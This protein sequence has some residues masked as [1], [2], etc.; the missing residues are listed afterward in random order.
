[1]KGEPYSLSS[2]L[3]RMERLVLAI[4]SAIILY[5]VVPEAGTVIRVSTISISRKSTRWTDTT[6]NFLAIS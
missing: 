4:Y 6:F 5:G 2:P 3:G 1:M